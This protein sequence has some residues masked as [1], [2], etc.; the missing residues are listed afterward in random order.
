M[1]E[2]AR[3]ATF[4]LKVIDEQ[5]LDILLSNLRNLRYS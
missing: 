2:T 3:N 5:D 1:F 4:N